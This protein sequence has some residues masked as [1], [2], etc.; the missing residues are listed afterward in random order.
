[1]DGVGPGS[2]RFVRVVG[3]VAA[4]RPDAEGVAFAESRAGDGT[5]G[6][7]GFDDGVVVSVGIRWA[8]SHLV[9]A[10]GSGG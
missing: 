1:M 10:V 2:P 8:E 3:I 4:S 6:V 9:E 7:G 5:E